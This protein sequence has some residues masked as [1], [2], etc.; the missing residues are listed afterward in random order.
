[1]SSLDRINVLL[2][3]IRPVITEKRDSPA[4]AIARGIFSEVPPVNRSL[5]RAIIILGQVV[6]S[7]TEFNSLKEFFE[8]MRVQGRNLTT[9]DLTHYYL[10]D[11]EVI[12]ILKYCPNLT[13]LTLNS[14]FKGKIPTENVIAAICSSCPRL[15]N[16]HLGAFEFT[17]TALGFLTQLPALTNLRITFSKG[18]TDAGL[19]QIGKISS[20]EQ[21]DLD[22]SFTPISNVGLSALSKL[23]RLKAINL[24]L[25]HQDLTSA[26]LLEL[27]R[28]PLKKLNLSSSNITDKDIEFFISNIKTLEILDLSHCRNL[29]DW[30][31]R[32]LGKLKQLQSLM[33][34]WTSITGITL[35]FLKG[36][37]LHTLDLSSCD[38]LGDKGLR[39]LAVLRKLQTLDLNFYR[40]SDQALAYLTWLPHLTTLGLAQNSYELSDMAL[41]S[42]SSISTLK[43]L[44]LSF[45]KSITS[46]GFSLLSRLTHLETLRLNGN[47]GL[48]DENLKSLSTLPLKTLELTE[49]RKLTGTGFAHLTHLPLENLAIDCCSGLTNQ[50]W[51]FLAQLKY[52]KQ[53]LCWDC[54][55]N[56][57]LGRHTLQPLIDQGLDVRG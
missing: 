22:L 39:A 44:D 25:A 34:R 37:S 53:L 9:L 54:N 10:H 57:M 17:D 2:G 24:N 42:I 5:E 32:F 38:N 14:E 23:P 56:L 8:Y 29:T 43:S 21:L 28:L 1:M 51:D 47:Q 7:K 27:T 48:T 49:C 35:I 19:E 4:V 52:L 45:H 15:Q 3:H 36:T 18:I 46:Y 30:G 11:D 12:E 50:I 33:L 40:C 16:L 41:D 13:S 26:G 20:L 55:L 6:P 31:I